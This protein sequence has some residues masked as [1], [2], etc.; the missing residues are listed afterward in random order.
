MG[1]IDAI[2]RF[3]FYCRVWDTRQMQAGDFFSCSAILSGMFLR[4]QHQEV[5]LLD[6][7][8]QLSEVISFLFLFLF[9]SHLLSSFSFIVNYSVCRLTVTV[10]VM[11]SLFWLVATGSTE[12]DVKPR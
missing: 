8:R 6:K 10:Q 4:K 9:L 5:D 3:A 1:N 11:G 12:R 7:L 2:S